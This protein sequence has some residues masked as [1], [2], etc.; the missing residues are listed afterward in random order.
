MEP[1]K[2][3][4]LTSTGSALQQ[5]SQPA[6]WQL[7]ELQY[8]QPIQPCRQQHSKSSNRG[9]SAASLQWKSQHYQCTTIGMRTKEVAGDKE[10]VIA[11]V[12]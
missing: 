1:T 8:K 11:T 5:S 10:E 9:L 7:E 2:Q 4:V 6:R 12:I 3:Q